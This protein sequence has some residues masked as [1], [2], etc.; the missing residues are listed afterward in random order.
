MR[1]LLLVAVCAFSMLTMDPSRWAIGLDEKLNTHHIAATGC[2][3]R[4]VDVIA[5]SSIGAR[6]VME[7]LTAQS[8][9]VRV[10]RG[11]VLDGGN[12]VQRMMV[13]ELNPP[14]NFSG[15]GRVY[16]A[17]MSQRFT[18]SK[19]EYVVDFGPY[20]RKSVLVNALCIDLDRP[21]IGPRGLSG[22][23]R[24]Y[25][26][27]SPAMDKL[28]AEVDRLNAGYQQLDP[29]KDYDDVPEVDLD[30]TSGKLMLS[31]EVYNIA[32]WKLRGATNLDLLRE[33]WLVPRIYLDTADRILKAAARN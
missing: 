24:V 10:L 2:P 16:A 30:E 6:L 27:N 20:E 32:V 19:K 23:P 26:L 4:V 29:E 33:L 28:F 13:A 18:T 8:V 1:R 17:E 14:G 3:V 22:A 7:N 5:S 25:L 9:K 31:P 11:T 12:A 15:T 21:V